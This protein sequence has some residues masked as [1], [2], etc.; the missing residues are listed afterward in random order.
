MVFSVGVLGFASIAGPEASLLDAVYMTVIT[1][2][3]VGYGEH[4]NLAHDPAGQIFAMLL[5]FTGVGAFMYFFTSTTAFVVDGSLYRLL[6]K[7]R[8]NKAISKLD[9]HVI[10]CGAGR[11]G[12]HIIEEF[13][14]T[15][16]P[17]VVVDKR[18]LS[19]T[20]LQDR[21]GINF[22]AVVGDAMDDDSLRAAGIDRAKGVMACLSRDNDN[23]I[24]VVSARLLNSETRI[25]CRS[26]DPRVSKKVLSAGADSVVSP[27]AIGGLRL[28]S[29]MV[30]PKVV[31]F[32]DR[33][34]RGKDKLLRVEE[35][36]IDASSALVGKTV[37]D[38]RRMKIK[39]LLVVALSQPGW[40][41]EYNPD[42]DVALLSGMSLIFMGS[43]D[44][45]NELASCG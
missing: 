37:G 29:E 44:A 12:A 16:F 14:T 18:E 42:D 32:L 8:M 26:I 36:E 15:G 1:L 41:W 22:P 40:N 30:R 35:Y 28:A 5:L 33:M 7:R 45:R 3:T 13:A 31:S 23:L 38:V 6:W 20:E 9:K 4:I 2:T 17:F 11:V 25:V 43:V 39:D 27:N 21:L 24:V 10:V 34:L 19:I